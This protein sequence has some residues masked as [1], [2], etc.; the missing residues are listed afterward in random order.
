MSDADAATKRARSPNH[1]RPVAARS[2]NPESDS[3]GR[4]TIASSAA[5]R[6]LSREVLGGLCV[7]WAGSCGGAGGAVNVAATVNVCVPSEP[8]EAVRRVRR[9]PGG[10]PDP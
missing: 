7:G 1:E 5:P 9:P 2:N 4:A 8:R 10:T 3:A 6:A